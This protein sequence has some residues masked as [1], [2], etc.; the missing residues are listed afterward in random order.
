[1]WQAVRGYFGSTEFIEDS[2]IKEEAQPAP[3][4]TRNV[5]KR[6][7][8]SD[9]DTARSMEERSYVDVVK[10]PRHKDA[11]PL[12]QSAPL[13]RA[14]R[15]VTT[16]TTLSHSTAKPT[17]KAET[18]TSDEEEEAEEVS[19]SQKRKSLSLAT[20]KPRKRSRRTTVLDRYTAYLEENRRV[21][22]KVYDPRC[23]NCV[24]S[25]I[26]VCAHPAMRT[27]CHYCLMGKR[28]C[29][30]NKQKQAK[31]TR[32]ST[33]SKKEVEQEEQETEG[34]EQEDNEE[35]GDK[36][37]EDEGG[38]PIEEDTPPLNTSASAPRNPGR[39]AGRPICLMPARSREAPKTN[40]GGIEVPV[41]Y[42]AV[43]DV[44]NKAG[45]RRLQLASVKNQI[46]A[47]E[48]EIDTRCAQLFFLYDLAST[49]GKDE[50]QEAEDDA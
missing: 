41:R 19:I 40:L 28:G 12:P 18:T 9:A 21:D 30:F 48:A 20:D 14:L 36:K 11:L 27:P 34:E 25:D 6:P 8:L 47:L 2:D 31:K 24:R 17:L 15:R 37:D 22:D 10:L 23:D 33:S 35:E 5:R 46:A 3:E 50:P 39:K 16:S 49:L 7:I 4:P 45:L 13:P 44:E 32:R 42:S 29:T 1:M 26:T 38:E 43:L